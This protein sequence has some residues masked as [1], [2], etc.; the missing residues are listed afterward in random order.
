MKNII[1]IINSLTIGGSEKSLISLLQLIDYTEYNVDLMMLKQGED[2]EKY[3]PKEVNIIDIPKYYRFI[4]KNKKE[5]YSFKER[6]KFLFYRYYT[7]FNLRVNSKKKVPINSEQVLYKSHSKVLN[8][9][10]KKYDV[11]IAYAQGFPTYYVVDKIKAKKKIAWINC[12]YSTTIYDKAFDY[13]YYMK[14]DK[15]VAVSETIKK[16]IISLRPEYKSKLKVIL[17][18]VNPELIKSMAKENLKLNTA[19]EE[20]IIL[21]VGRLV[22][23]HKG[24]D[25]A[26]EAAKILKNSGY[27]FKWYIVGDGPDRKKIEQMIINND[28]EDCFILLGKKDNP[29]PYMNICNIYV[30]PSRKEGFGLTVVEAKILNKLILCTNFNTASEIVNNNIDGLIVDMNA[31]SI[32][33]GIIKYINDNELRSKI[34]NNLLSSSIYNSV[35]EI[36]KIY[37]ILK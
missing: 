21:T 28:L 25:I 35:N 2:L 11:A 12:D 34:K 10:E 7:S 3:I 26:V 22:I 37:E 1:F 4:S 19:N 8:K 14:I 31:K 13:R 32:C 23:H 6:L 5:K 15:I 9:L 33:D 20:F 36:N 24:Y 27:K 16:S 30:Q 29:Y 18:I 17:D